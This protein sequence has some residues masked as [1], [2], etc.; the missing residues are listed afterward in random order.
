M[1]KLLTNCNTTLFL[2]GGQ[3]PGHELRSNAVHVQ[4]TREIVCTLPYDTLTIAVMSLMVLRRTSCTSRRIVSTFLCVELVESRP[5]L[6]SSSTD[7]VP[8][9]KRAC[10]SK[11]LARLMASFPY[12]RRIIS[13]VSAP[14]LPSFAQNLMFAVCCSFTSMLK[15]QM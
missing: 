13:K 8:F 3:K 7:D 5:D 9:L 4:I 2:F 6:S 12:A 11:H 15:S 10:H 14:D 1:T